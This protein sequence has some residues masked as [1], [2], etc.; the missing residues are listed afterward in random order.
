MKTSFNKTVHVRVNNWGEFSVDLA[1]YTV[2]DFFFKRFVERKLLAEGLP[3]EPMVATMV[4][5]AALDFGWT[6]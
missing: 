4:K 6:L 1:I 5:A 2:P 3:C